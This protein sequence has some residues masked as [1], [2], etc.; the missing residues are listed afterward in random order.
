MFTTTRPSSPQLNQRPARGRLADSAGMASRC[1]AARRRARMG[2]G[3]RAHDSVAVSRFEIARGDSALRSCWPADDKEAAV[4]EERVA[5]DPG[6][7]ARCEERH[8]TGAGDSGSPTQP[9]GYNRLRRSAPPSC[10]TQT[11]VLVVAGATAFTRISSR[12]SSGRRR[13][14]RGDTGLR[15]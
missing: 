1:V 10:P 5:R 15:R 8:R 14:Q 7:A 13:R 3:R 9:S 12:A 2:S 4:G 11:R 6:R